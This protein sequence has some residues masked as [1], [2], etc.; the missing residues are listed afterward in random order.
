MKL[1]SSRLATLA[2]LLLSAPLWMAACSGGGS[3]AGCTKD[4]DCK[5]DR[6]CANGSCQDAPSRQNNNQGN[7]AQ[8]NNQGNP[9][10]NTPQNNTPPPKPPPA[11][12]A[13]TCAYGPTYWG[14]CGRTG[15]VANYRCG[16]DG[17]CIC[18]CP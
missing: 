17:T 15:C 10:N 9:Q 12:R 2:L 4:S 1:P 14:P 16:E 11:H 8:N 6:I 3:G 5:G 18:N 13:C 7:N